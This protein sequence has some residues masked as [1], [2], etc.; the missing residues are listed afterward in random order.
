M[1]E[2]LHEGY[3]E[4]EARASPSTLSMKLTDENLTLAEL[5]NGGTA[6]CPARTLHC[7]HPQHIRN[8]PRAVLRTQYPLHD[9]CGAC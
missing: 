6:R 4:E 7:S 9:A 2:S 5:A 3:E 8:P 1:I